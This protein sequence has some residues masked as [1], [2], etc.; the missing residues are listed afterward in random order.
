MKLESLGALDAQL[1]PE[2]WLGVMAA[3]VVLTLLGAYLY[4]LGPSL[5]RYREL[6]RSWSA[7][8][9]VSAEVRAAAIDAEIAELEQALVGLDDRIYGSSSG[10]PR[11]QIES[12]II[13]QL[14]ELSNRRDVRLASVKP[15]L[16]GDVLSFEELPYDVDVSGD[17]FTLFDWLGAVENELRPLAV[18]RFE[19]R[20]AGRTDHV[21]L[22]LRLVSYRP[23]EDRS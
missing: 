21:Q 20:P 13:A 12:H 6:A 10:L 23:R 19:M 4:L 11:E 8:E 22:Q 9:L 15:G 17:Y 16:T 5:A 7:D 3:V 14:D 18:K 2:A 1:R